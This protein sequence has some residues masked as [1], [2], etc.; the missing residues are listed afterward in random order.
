MLHGSVAV[1]YCH[2]QLVTNATHL[3]PTSCPPPSEPHRLLEQ[4]VVTFS[5]L[6]LRPCLMPIQ[7]HNVRAMLL[8]G[9]DAGLSCPAVPL[10]VPVPLAVLMPLAMLVPKL[11]SVLAVPLL[12]VTNQAMPLQLLRQPQGNLSLSLALLPLLFFGIQY[13][14]TDK[15]KRAC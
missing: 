4:A 7:G 11:I 10:A 8:L 2:M 12:A 14:C 6:K 13:P 15:R 5:P 1:I 3:S 9:G